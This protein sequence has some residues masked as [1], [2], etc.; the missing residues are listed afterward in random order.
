MVYG[1]HPY[2]RPLPRHLDSLPG[3]T[4]TI[5]WPGISRIWTADNLQIVVSGDLDPTTCFSG[6]KNS[7]ADL[8]PAAGGRR[9]GPRVPT[10]PTRRRIVSGAH[11]QEAE[12]ERGPGG[13]ARAP[14]PRQRTGCP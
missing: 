11:R 13:L 14:G 10:R 1:D 5:W 4:G 8:P 2:G 12:P 9:P 6:W 7:L 3:L